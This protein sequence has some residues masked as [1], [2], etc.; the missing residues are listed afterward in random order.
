MEIIVAFSEGGF[1][2]FSLAI[3]DA[4]PRN[5]CVG[6]H[7][8]QGIAHQSCLAKKS[9]EVGDLS[10]GCNLSVGDAFD[11]F[12]DAI[13]GVHD[14]NSNVCHLRDRSLFV[15][16]DRLRIKEGVAHR[17]NARLRIKPYTC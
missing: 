4:M 16:R 10:V 9:G 12:V 6:C 7:S 13:V 11:G 2:D 5:I 15:S 8:E 3:N 1:G 14:P 17:E